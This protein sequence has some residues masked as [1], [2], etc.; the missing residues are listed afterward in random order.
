V[1]KESEESREWSVLLRMAPET[2]RFVN[3]ISRIRVDFQL[4]DKSKSS[5]DRPKEISQSG[6][7]SAV[8]IRGIGQNRHQS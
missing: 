7:N 5:T 8:L 4:T 6:T 2:V 1:M 3:I